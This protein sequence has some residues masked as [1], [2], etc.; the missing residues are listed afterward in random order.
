MPVPNLQGQYR[1]RWRWSREL[2]LDQRFGREAFEWRLDLNSRVGCVA[3]R[4]NAANFA[5]QRL[6]FLRAGVLAGSSSGFARNV[7]LH[8]RAAVVVGTC[9]KAKLRQAAIKL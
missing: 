7:L 5:N 6:E 1:R 3:L 8:Q 4:G 2:R 9:L